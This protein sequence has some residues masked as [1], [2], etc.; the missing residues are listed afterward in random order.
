MP[1]LPGQ[2]EMIIGFGTA[3]LCMVGFVKCQWF[4]DNTTKGQR[5]VDRFGPEKA[6][7]VFRLMMMIGCIFG[8]LLGIGIIKPIQW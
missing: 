6:A 8:G 7:T 4:L 2:N 5:L 1:D 3:G